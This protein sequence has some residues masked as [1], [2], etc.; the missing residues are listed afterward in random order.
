MGG[1]EDFMKKLAGILAAVLLV[2]AL[3]PGAA[4]AANEKVV[5]GEALQFQEGNGPLIINE[6]LMLP[7]RAVSEALDATIYWF[8]DDK[9]IQIVLYD[10]LLSLQIGNSI[11]GQYTIKNG[12]AEPKENIEM[13]VPATIQND[14]TYVPVRAISEAF[15]ADVQWD[16][17]NRTAVI[18]PKPRTENQVV[19]SEIPYQAEGTLCALTGV[20]AKDASNGSF[21]L[22]SL[23][24]NGIGSYDKVY[25]CTPTKTS[26]SED[27]SYGEYISA[28]WKEQ[29]GN[30][31]PA[32]E[33][34]RFTGITTLIDG[35]QHLVINKTT[36]GIRSLGYYDTYMNN[37]GMSFDAFANEIS[38]DTES[39]ILN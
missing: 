22:R 10:T 4:F 15:S 16:N 30:D 38:P 21:Y 19:V 7:L 28:Y 14:R 1:M 5:V 36:T 20:I 29:F 34:V 12:K 39:D 35:V 24:K 31:N 23:Q 8:N 13:D 17:P 2:G 6:R 32:G 3:V 27:T 9:R 26:I 11:M 25:F 37:L 18:I 33:V